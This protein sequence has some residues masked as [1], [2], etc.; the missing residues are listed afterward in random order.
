MGAA[1]PTSTRGCAPRLPASS[2]C[3]TGPGQK[4]RTR[5]R[6]LSAAR[7][8]SAE[9]KLFNAFHAYS[10]SIMEFGL[11]F[12]TIYCTSIPSFFFWLLFCLGLYIS[13]QLVTFNVH[14]ET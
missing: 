2:K 4:R 3:S 9:D 13:K 14:H 12:V 8:L 10:T 5:R 6:R 1:R 11:N 7:R